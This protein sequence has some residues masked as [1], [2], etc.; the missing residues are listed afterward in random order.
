MSPPFPF[1]ISAILQKTIPLTCPLLEAPLRDG[2]R[3]ARIWGWK[4]PSEIIYI[5]KA[6]EAALAAGGGG[7]RQ[8]L[9]SVRG[10][11]GWRTRP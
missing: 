5:I 6:G 10:N 4:P 1:P 8:H 2:V 9:W 11:T 3:I 7:H